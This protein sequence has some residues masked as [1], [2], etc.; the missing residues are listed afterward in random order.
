MNA[1][2]P[3]QK[4]ALNLTLSIYFTVYEGMDT[5]CVSLIY[6]ISDNSTMLRL[7]ITYSM[8]NNIYILIFQVSQCIWE[9]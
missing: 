4:E 8:E 2:K 5:N 7:I 9:F 3:S 6:N 1:C